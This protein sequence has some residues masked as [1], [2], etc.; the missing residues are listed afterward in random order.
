MA[1]REL[2]AVQE[3]LRVSTALAELCWHQLRCASQIALASTMPPVPPTVAFQPHPPSTLWVLQA[4][5]IEGKTLRFCYDRLV[6]LMKTLEARHHPGPPALHPLQRVGSNTQR[7]GSSCTVAAPRVLW[8]EPTLGAIPTLL[9]PLL[10]P[11]VTATDDYSAL[12]LVADFA[13]LVGTYTSGFA[14]ITEPYDERMPSVRA[15]C[16]RWGLS[17]YSTG[18]MLAK[19]GAVCGL[20]AAGWAVA[21]R[22]AR[23]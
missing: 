5:A 6:S 12:H 17:R 9:L 11:Q 15:L 14:I 22:Y 2:Q 19:L 8:A 13:T 16:V 10:L 1:R 4:V 18:L 7:V 20:M 21:G 3:G 23:R